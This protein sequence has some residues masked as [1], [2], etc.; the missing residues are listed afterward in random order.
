MDFGSRRVGKGSA[1]T[2][3]PNKIYAILK[4]LI[5]RITRRERKEIFASMHLRGDRLISVRHPLH[6]NINPLPQY[7]PMPMAPH[8][9]NRHF[10]IFFSDAII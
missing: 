3:D 6:H 8:S 2:M 4:D 5:A 9:R 1:A 10:A 7:Q